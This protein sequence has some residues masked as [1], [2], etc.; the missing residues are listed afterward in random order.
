M[1]LFYQEL[2]GGE[3]SSHER[4]QVCSVTE[5]KTSNLEE[6]NVSSFIARGYLWVKGGAHPDRFL[7]IK[8]N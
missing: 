8:G 2:S 4:I 5:D 1:S 6:L 3:Q 7:P